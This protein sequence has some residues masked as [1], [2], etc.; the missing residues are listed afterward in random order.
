MLGRFNLRRFIAELG[1]AMHSPTLVYLY[2]LDPVRGTP[3]PIFPDPAPYL[4]APRSSK[5]GSGCTQ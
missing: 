1:E 2:Y 3:A 5:P 4:R